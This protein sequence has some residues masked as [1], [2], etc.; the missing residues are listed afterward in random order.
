MGTGDV[1]LVIG[2]QAEVTE[3]KRGKLC[4]EDVSG[5]EEEDGEAL[6]GE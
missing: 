4:R 6:G 1:G 5:E 3:D 2:W